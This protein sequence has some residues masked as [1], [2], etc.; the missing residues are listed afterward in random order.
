MFAE[1]VTKM[2]NPLGSTDL[3]PCISPWVTL[4]NWMLCIPPNLNQISW[5]A[6]NFQILVIKK[7]MIGKTYTGHSNAAIRGGL[8]AVLGVTPDG[9][10]LAVEGSCTD[11]FEAD[12]VLED[13][14]F[15]VL[16]DTRVSVSQDGAFHL[17][18]DR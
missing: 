10:A 1:F 2:W 8:V 5:S 3:M 18:D 7:V 15:A 17:K 9:L 12:N 6:T 13:E 11:E 14:P 16:K 4:S